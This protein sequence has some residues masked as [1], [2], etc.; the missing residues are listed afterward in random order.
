MRLKIHDVGHG[1]CISLLHENGNS[2]VWDCGHLDNHKPSDFLVQEGIQ[3]ID[4]FFVT[5]FDN[6]HISDL[7]L[8]RLRLPIHVLHRNQSVDAAA[9]RQIK[10]RSGP[11]TLAMQSM[12]D[13]MEDHRGGPPSI[14]P[15]FPNVNFSTYCNSFTEFDDTNNCSVVTFLSCNGLRFVFPGDVERAGWLKLLERPDFQ[16]ELRGV[17]IFVASHHGR[18][19]GYCSDV[20]EICSPKAVVFSDDSIKFASQEMSNTYGG[21]CSGIQFN[22]NPRRVLTTRNDGSMWWDL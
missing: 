18:E 5:N 17:D 21:H 15:S 16:N 14:P 6:D 11:I 1:G 3:K 22:G 2:M 7:P 13:M 8:L 9:L 20:F 12:L 4:R 19:S 10:A